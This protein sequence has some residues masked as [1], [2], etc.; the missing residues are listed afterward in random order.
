MMN[1]KF[2]KP[3][4]VKEKITENI[5]DYSDYKVIHT[6]VKQHSPNSIVIV[7][8]K[9]DDWFYY[10]ITYRTKTGIITDSSMIIGSDLESWIRSITQ[11]G[12][13]ITK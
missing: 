13:E 3:K 9:N 1:K 7:Q 8:D 6:F 4:T 2:N 10:V 11:A 5:K 12:F